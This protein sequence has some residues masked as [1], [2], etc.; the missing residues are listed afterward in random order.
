MV[1]Y[2]RILKCHVLVEL[3]VDEFNS[4]HTSQLQAYLNFYN[5]N[6]RAKGDNPPIG[7]LL[8]TNKNNALV[9]YASAGITEKMFVSKYAVALPTKK[10]LQLFIKN[11]LKKIE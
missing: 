4:G 10:Q 3:K 1:F 2:H 8:V 9:E 7:I 6:F 11:E 5:K